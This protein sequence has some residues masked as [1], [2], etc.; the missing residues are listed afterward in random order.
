MPFEM[1][2]I[3][4]DSHLFFFFL[5]LAVY[6]HGI[7]ASAVTRRACDTVVC[8]GDW[9]LWPNVGSV[10]DPADSVLDW[11][12]PDSVKTPTDTPKQTQPDVEL[13][14]TSPPVKEC[15]AAALPGSTDFSE[16]KRP[17][18]LCVFLRTSFF[19]YMKLIKAVFFW[20]VYVV[21]GV[22]EYWPMPNGYCAYSLAE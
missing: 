9:G 2:R 8:P 15:D 13:Q 7:F 10:L 20:H 4:R 1:L 22:R 11:L 12:L 14:V 19:R 18:S 17:E 6:Y 3:R 16:R 21:T 5:L